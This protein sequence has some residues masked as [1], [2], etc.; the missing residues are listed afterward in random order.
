MNAPRGS[1]LIETR[2]LGA[3]WIADSFYFDPLRARRRAA[4][5]ASLADRV[6]LAGLTLRVSRYHFVRVSQAGQV[7]QLWR[8]GVLVSGDGAEKS[9]A[10]AVHT[11]H[12]TA[13]D[14]P[15]QRPIAGETNREDR[16]AH[17]HPEAQ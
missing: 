17:A 6:E 4:A 1:W 3:E 16:S 8:A 15:A 9:Y 11:P 7:V 13:A 2:E 12:R 5:L 10:P 14:S